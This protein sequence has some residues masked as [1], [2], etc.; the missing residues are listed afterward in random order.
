MIQEIKSKQISMHCIMACIYFLLLPTT[1]AV[2]SAGNSIL[3]LA[4]IPIGLYFLATIIISNRK[5]QINGVHLA[6]LVF[7]LTTV[8]T[9]F[10]N[11]EG[12][13]VNHV[14]ANINIININ[15]KF[16]VEYKS[17]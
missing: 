13:S 16:F 4:T 15:E 1:I 12:L 17:I 10:V 2:N 11:T 8:S 6:L 9:L 14:I 7:T 3:K 5:L